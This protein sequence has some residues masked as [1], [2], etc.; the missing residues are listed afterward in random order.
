MTTNRK[1]FTLVEIMLVVGIIGML[2]A[3]AIPNLIRARETTQRNKC[4]NNARLLMDAVDQWAIENNKA[5]N[6]SPASNCSD[7]LPYIKNNLLPVCKAGTAY[8]VSGNVTNISV[9]CGGGS[10]PHGSW[11]SV[12][13][14]E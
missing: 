8:T 2:A 1:G 11:T 3:L 4:K 9:N 7:L 12:S 10:G 13:L 6:D 14:S 5:S